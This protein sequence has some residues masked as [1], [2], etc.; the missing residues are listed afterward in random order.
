MKVVKKKTDEKFITLDV[1]ASSHEV[2][3]ALNQASGVFC[4]QMGLYPE[5]GKTPA[6]VA[7]EKLGI[8]NLDEAVTTQTV[9]LIVP[10]AINKSGIIPAYLPPAEPK[11]RLARGHAF[12][13][14]IKVMPKPTYELESYDPVKITIEPFQADESAI[15]ERISEMAR[16]YTTFVA[17]DPKPLERGDSC[18]LKMSTTKDGET[19]AGLTTESRSYTL[20]QDLMPVGFDEHLEGME[21]GE[22][23]TFQFEGPGLDSD[24]NEVMEGYETTITLLELQKE[25][26]PV[27]NDEWVRKNLPMY[28]DLADLRAKLGEE[29][30]VERK[31]YYEDYKRN[32]AASELSKR[33]TGSIPDEV[34]EGSIRETRD[35]MRQQVA[36]QGMKWEDFVEQNGGE[37]QV[38]MM[39]M[40]ETRQQLVIGYSLDAYYRH[41]GLMY[42]EDDLDEVCF[43]MSPRNPKQARQGME[44]N[45]FGYALRES[46]ERLRACKHLVEHAE[47]EV[48]DVPAASTTS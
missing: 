6:Q 41:E 11:T 26:V 28:T 25:V 34:Y 42:T 10:Q 13:F 14:E 8:K 21:V 27:V 16:T 23:R 5:R 38:N 48:R 20:G 1:T 19:V 24:M 37:Q 4:Q 2:S 47:I 7:S 33:F 15:D 36:R 35:N 39:M 3:A 12:Q 44:R 17:A 45:G 31:K 9:E 22:T 43:Q 18:L 30:N 29:T 40:V 46:A 32:M